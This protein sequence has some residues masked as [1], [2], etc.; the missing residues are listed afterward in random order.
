MTS[1]QRV[2]FV[3]LGT[4]G[5]RMAANLQK[6]GYQL[7][8]NDLRKD[9]ADSLIAGGALWA[10]TPQA[11]AEQANVFFTSLPEP[12]DV[13][14]AALGPKGL[15]AGVKPGSAFFDLS[16]NS[17]ITVNKLAA[18]FTEKGAHM[19]DAPV[20]GGPRGAETRKM[21][22]WVGG[23]ERVYNAHKSVLDAMGDQARYIGPIGTATIAKLVHNMSGYAMVCAYAETFSLGV[24]AG[25]DPLDLWQ[26]VRQG[27]GGRRLTFDGLLDQFLPGKYDP[28]SFALRLAHKDVALA[29]GLGRE[30]GMPMRMCNLVFAEMTE[31]L[32]RGW[33][34]RDSRSVMLLQQERAGINIAVEPERLRSATTPAKE[35]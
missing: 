20:S 6:G 18:A 33:A 29:N 31:A 28:P 13:E 21:A 30:L 8:V 3:G 9:T 5:S 16:T 4:M 2:G 1:Q 19:L 27:A 7:I 11:V 14:N 25:M 32:N 12:A 23:D 17:P 26:A 24:K 10:E 34:N 35:R 22:I 15:L